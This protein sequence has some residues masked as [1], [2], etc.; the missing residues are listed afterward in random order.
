MNTHM[1]TGTVDGDPQTATVGADNKTKV[2]FRLAEVPGPGWH[3]VTI[4]QGDAPTP[5]KGDLVYVE[6]R[7]QTRKYEKD[8]R[9]AY[10]TETVAKVCRP[11]GGEAAADDDLGFGD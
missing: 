1:L 3:S 2:T 4:W 10:F 9:D 8:G 7:V 6:G 5:S 11:I